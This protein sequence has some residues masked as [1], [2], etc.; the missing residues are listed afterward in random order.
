MKDRTDSVS[1]DTVARPFAD[2]PTADDSA[3]PLPLGSQ[4]L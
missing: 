3:R 1:F 2:R 4:T